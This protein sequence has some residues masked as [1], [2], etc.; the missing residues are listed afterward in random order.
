M[1]LVHK[2]VV[3][4]MGAYS[5]LLCVWECTVQEETVYSCTYT[6]QARICRHNN[7][8]VRTDKHRRT[9]YVILARYWHL[10]P[11]DGSNV[12]RNMSEQFL[13]F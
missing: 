4:I 6:Q 9:T 7:D 5:G 8:H 1:V 10:L 11:E 3:S 2:N 13:Y 12:N